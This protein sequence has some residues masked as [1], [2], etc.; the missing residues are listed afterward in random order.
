[1]IF[2][3]FLS[4]T[5]LCAVH[6][7]FTSPSLLFIFAGFS[8]RYCWKCFAQS[9][10]GYSFANKVKNCFIFFFSTP[11]GSFENFAAI[12]C[13]IVH[14]A[15]P[16]SSLAGT[17]LVKK[18]SADEDEPRSCLSSFRWIL[19]PVQKICVCCSNAKKVMPQTKD[20]KIE[21]D[22]Q[23]LLLME[24]LYPCIIYAFQCFWIH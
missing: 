8:L 24:L 7:H 11:S 21:K 20:M 22:V 15:L 13:S 2:F 4:L 5:A 6:I 10:H 16:N 1:M 3:P 19:L 14:P 23:R 18:K 12:R 9:G 17:W